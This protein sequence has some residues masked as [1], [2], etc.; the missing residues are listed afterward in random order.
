M[1][2]YI[3]QNL[4]MHTE[5]RNT[6]QLAYFESST[7]PEQHR[8]VLSAIVT[9][10]SASYTEIAEYFLPS[11]TITVHEDDPFGRITINLPRFGKN[12]D[13]T[14][15][16]LI[17]GTGNQIMDKRHK[18]EYRMRKNAFE[19][20]QGGF[21]RMDGHGFIYSIPRSPRSKQGILMEAVQSRNSYDSQ[22]ASV[23]G[24]HLD[25]DMHR[26]ASEAR[27]TGGARYL[28]ADISEG[29]VPL[30]SVPLR[31][32]SGYHAHFDALQPVSSGEFMTDTLRHLV[33]SE[34]ETERNAL[35]ERIL[36]LELPLR[37]FNR[38]NRRSYIDTRIFG[39]TGGYAQIGLLRLSRLAGYL[40]FGTAEIFNLKDR[41][42]AALDYMRVSDG[43]G[44]NYLPTSRI[45]FEAGTG[46]ISCLDRFWDTA[47][48][49]H[50]QTE[51][52]GSTAEL[53][54]DTSE[55]AEE[56]GDPYLSE[57]IETPDGEVVDED[58]LGLDYVAARSDKQ[59]QNGASGEHHMKFTVKVVA[60]ALQTRTKLLFG[61]GV[62]DHV[63]EEVWRLPLPH[64]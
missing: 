45:A 44:H 38:T 8:R 4:T 11:S 1:V 6:S 29:G 24:F 10:G 37:D 18:D 63:S 52:Q 15:S 43:D 3:D 17:L 51:M 42:A 25:H 23:L 26:L 21:V 33:W 46:D 58:A 53:Q 5:I 19:I 49:Y 36:A 12:G 7:A 55:Q 47:F 9:N 59:R 50:N 22:F 56:P 34:D 31:I 28:L 54:A 16:D 60:R 30:T 61:E 41:Y 2:C 48:Y 40:G 39:V 64:A 35:T 57:Q 20:S 62:D 13:R 14:L 27:T 32:N